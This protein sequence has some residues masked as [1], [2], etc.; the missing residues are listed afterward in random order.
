MSKSVEQVWVIQSN[1]I[2]TVHKSYSSNGNDLDNEILSGFIVALFSFASSRNSNNVEVIRMKGKAIHYLSEPGYIIAI[3]TEPR[4]NQKEIKK[5]LEDI[6][7]SLCEICD[8]DAVNLVL[9]TNDSTIE[10]FKQK[11][12]EILGYGSTGEKY[13]LGEIKTFSKVP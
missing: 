8:P 11:L 2:C 12:D 1:G 3:A 5:I 7:E 6:N 9:S 4:S 10:I 13:N